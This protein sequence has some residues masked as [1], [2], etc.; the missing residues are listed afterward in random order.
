MTST[1]LSY[2]MATTL[3]LVG[4]SADSS[5]SVPMGADQQ[6]QHRGHAKMPN[7]DVEAPEVGGDGTYVYRGLHSR[8]SKVFAGGHR[9]AEAQGVLFPAPTHST[10]LPTISR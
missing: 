7:V 9:L 5:F 4:A 2:Q 1:Y 3:S 10:P 6:G 8:S